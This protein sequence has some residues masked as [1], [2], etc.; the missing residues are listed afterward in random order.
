MATSEG[1]PR[2]LFVMNAVLSAIFSATIVWGLAFVGAIAFS[3][4]TVTLGAGVLFCLTYLVVL[5]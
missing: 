5:R 4:R 1:D 3:W 2:V